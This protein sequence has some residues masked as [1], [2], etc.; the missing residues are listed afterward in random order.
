MITCIFCR[1]QLVSDIEDVEVKYESHLKEWHNIAVDEERKLAIYRTRE[2]QL[3]T[4][5]HVKGKISVD[6]DELDEKIKT[7]RKTILAV[8]YLIPIENENYTAVRN[9]VIS[10]GETFPMAADYNQNIP[11]VSEDNVN[12]EIRS[13]V[14]SSKQ[15]LTPVAHV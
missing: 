14:K 15:F 11:T 3:A 4:E 7:A 10:N 9:K 13:K 6:G 5:L 2:K 1:G 8:E 12:N